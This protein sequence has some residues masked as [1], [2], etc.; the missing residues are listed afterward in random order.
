MNK[1]LFQNASKFISAVSIL[2]GTIIG[3]G[4][5][6]L[7]YITSK[8]GLWIVLGYF[9]VLS[10]LVILVHQMLGEIALKTPDY[11]RFPGFAKYHLGKGGELTAYISNI[12]GMLG[13]LLA[14]LI[15]G[16]RFL[17]NIFQNNHLGGSLTIW[18]IF[19]FAIGAVLIFLGV[20]TVA[21]VEFWGLI[22]F[23]AALAVIFLKGLSAINVSNLFPNLSS[24]DF[25]LPYGPVLFSLWG[26]SLI[27][28]AEET[29][30][31]EKR[32]LN[33]AI[34]I[35]I[36]IPI[37]VYLFF[38]FITLGI[39][40]SQT[41]EDALG[42]LKNVLG[43]GISNLALLF[44]VLTSFTSFIAVGL[45]LKKIFAYDLKLNKTLSWAITCFVPLMLF[46]A[47]MQSFIKVISFIGGTVIGVDGILILLMY[48][49]IRKERKLLTIP[50]ILVFISGIIYEIVYF[51]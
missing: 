13:T 35:S 48:Q 25:F 40:G 22:L 5:F 1:L 43:D 51:F 28:E 7:P 50:L 9:L 11:S 32:L 21:E 18:T 23:F 26:A 15:V 16:G 3:V 34:L 33:K 20:K 39:S 19:Y 31:G 47:G 44:G 27:P 49:K 12:I 42:G 8:V 37:F 41:T 29:L 6:S 46:L 38:I 30:Q 10:S 36:L 24:Y 17:T 45:T 4:L 2:A 14:Y